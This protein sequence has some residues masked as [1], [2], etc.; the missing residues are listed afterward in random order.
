[1]R[2]GEKLADLR[3][4]AGRARGLD[5][6]LSK[7]EMV[8]LMREEL[9]S[10]VSHAYVS[11]LELGRRVHLSAHTRELLA[12]FFRV[13]PGYLVDDPEHGADGAASWANGPAGSDNRLSGPRSYGADPSLEHVMTRLS[14]VADPDRDLVLIER[15]LE[16]PLD[17]AEAVVREQAKGRGGNDQGGAKKGMSA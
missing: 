8:R 14:N 1:V 6:P 16:L 2:L 15:L 13:H 7:V 11:Q 4:R 10:T 3:E 9:G 17:V 12:R 5:R